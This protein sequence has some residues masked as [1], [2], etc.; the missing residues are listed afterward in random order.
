MEGVRKDRTIYRA[1]F[2]P[3]DELYSKDELSE[4]VKE[5]SAAANEKNFISE[6]D[7]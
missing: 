6:V 4:L 2:I 5:F 3:L 7:L 1:R